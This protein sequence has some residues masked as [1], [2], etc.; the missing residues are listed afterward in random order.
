MGIF[1]FYYSYLYRHSKR[2][3]LKFS[4]IFF[5]LL[6]IFQLDIVQ[7]TENQF[8]I[9]RNG[10][11]TNLT[12]FICRTIHNVIRQNAEIK[13]IAIFEFNNQFSNGFSNE[14]VK[15][16]PLAKV[17][18]NKISK[19]NIFGLRKKFSAY[20][21]ELILIICDEIEKVSENFKEIYIDIMFSA[22]L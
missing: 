9:D 14:I 11:D 7:N 6:L 8:Q 18:I 16:L 3:N 17:S 5:I 15:C 21:S 12:K 2:M 19:N 4:I 20:K 10:V 1:L 22:N 13:G